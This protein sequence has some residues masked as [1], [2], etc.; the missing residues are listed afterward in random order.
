MNEIKHW[1]DTLIALV[2]A[3]VVDI[4]ANARGFH[5]YYEVGIFCAAY[6][7]GTQVSQLLGIYHDRAEDRRRKELHR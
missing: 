3:V 1:I 4:A 2:V 5:W 7:L 6:L